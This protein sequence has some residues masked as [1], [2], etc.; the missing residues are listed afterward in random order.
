MKMKKL[1]APYTEEYYEK[2]MDILFAK[3]GNFCDYEE[4]LAH[5]V[6]TFED[7]DIPDEYKEKARQAL[8]K[9]YAPMIVDKAVDQLLDKAG[10]IRRIKSGKSSLGYTT[11]VQE[12]NAMHDLVE[13]FEFSCYMLE[14]FKQKYGVN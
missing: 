14:K 6:P 4:K 8:I 2:Y 7:V 11:W 5:Y 9:V 3:Y 10:M 13:G 12:I 1:Q